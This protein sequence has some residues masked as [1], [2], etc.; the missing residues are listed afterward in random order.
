MTVTAQSGDDTAALSLDGF[1]AVAPTTDANGVKTWTVSGLPVPPSDVIVTSNKGGVDVEDVVIT[2]S[3]N[4]S[5]QVVATITGD[6]KTLQVEQS[7]SL[8]GLWSTGT[9]NSYALSI[10]PAAGTTM[11]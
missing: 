1:P 5:A 6:T 10:S 9:I 7:L 8:D 3:E 11:L 2:G 4:P